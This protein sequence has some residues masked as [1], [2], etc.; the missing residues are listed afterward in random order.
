MTTCVTYTTDL[1]KDKGLQIVD[2][3]QVIDGITIYP[4]E[5]FCPL[6]QFT[7][8]LNITDNSYSIHKYD[9]A[10]AGE[11]VRYGYHLKW[12]YI[13]RFGVHLG[14]VLYLIPYSIYIIKNDGWKA[15]FDKFFGKLKKGN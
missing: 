9:G 15:F 10:W 5:Y 4:V 7:G 3:I 14:K 11:T 13:S 1:L 6:N 8:Q 12:E 2:D